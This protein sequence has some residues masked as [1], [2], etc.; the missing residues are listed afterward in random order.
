MTE[1]HSKVIMD[2]V[3]TIV[4]SLY[5]Y[6]TFPVYV[7]DISKWIPYSMLKMVGRL[8]RHVTTFVKYF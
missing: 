8:S 3:F 2:T 4:F 5:I 7:A 6:L 1:R